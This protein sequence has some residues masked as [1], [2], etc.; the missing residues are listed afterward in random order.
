MRV[1]LCHILLPTGMFP[2]LW[3]NFAGIPTIS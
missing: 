2:E 3:A 1:L